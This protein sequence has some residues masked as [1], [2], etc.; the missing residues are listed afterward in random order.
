MHAAIHG[1]ISG[2]ELPFY[3][4]SNFRSEKNEDGSSRP[5][6]VYFLIPSLSIKVRYLSMSVFFR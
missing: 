3:P 6:H 4:I 1:H 2:L 5:H